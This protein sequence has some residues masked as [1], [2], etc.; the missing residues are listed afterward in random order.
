MK[1]QL[2]EKL[3]QYGQSHLLQFWDDLNES[4]QASLGQQINEFDFELIQSL[5]KDKQASGNQ[6]AELAARA[7][8][9]PAIT[10]KDFA[11]RESYD[12]AHA[13]GKSA[14]EAGKLGMILVA[15]GQGSRL[16]F[17]HP[18]GMFPI[19]PVSDCSLYQIHFE[20]VLARSKQ[21]GAT[22]PLYVM[23]SPPTHEETTE[24]LA[25]NNYFGIPESDVKIFCQGVMPA[26]DETGKLLLESKSKVFVSPDGHGGTLGAFV[27]SGC[28]DDAKSRGVEHIFYGQ[29]DNPLIQICDPALIGYHLKSKSEM[30]SQV[31]R[32]NEPTQKVGNVVLVDD[33]VQI[34]EYLSLIHI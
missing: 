5:F 2:E 14:L 1:S 17:N 34:I 6:W 31:V 24:F 20:K 12:E 9:P 16:G 3:N 28:L 26:V 13:L 25:E 22:I 29:V 8:V 33:A 11:N 15:G 23:T 32:K 27:K 4:E 7:E 21:F 30:T 18:K 19:G 10:L